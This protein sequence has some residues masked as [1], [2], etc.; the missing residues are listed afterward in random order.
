MF[1]YIYNRWCLLRKTFRFPPPTLVVTGLIVSLDLWNIK[2]AGHQN[3]FV[4]NAGFTHTHTHTQII[5]SLYLCDHS[6]NMYICSISS[7]FTQSMV[8]II[9]IIIILGRISVSLAVWYLLNSWK[10]PLVML[11]D[12]LYDICSFVE[13]QESWKCWS[14][15]CINFLC[16]T[17]SWMFLNIFQFTL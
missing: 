12:F 16:V 2:Q 15:V 17:N 7:C 14:Y 4:L 11:C 13:A 1:I 9:I 3:L 6:L 5:R 8:I 10:F